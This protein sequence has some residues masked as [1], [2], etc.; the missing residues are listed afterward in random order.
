MRKAKGELCNLYSSP[1][2][3]R[4]IRMR[5]VGH[6]PHIGKM[7]NVYKSLVR[8]PEG[9]RSQERLGVDRIK[10]K[11]ILGKYVGCGLDSSGIG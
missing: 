9:K 5:W 8:K 4:M 2:F 7:R 1:N 6:G 10:L 11:W 3:I